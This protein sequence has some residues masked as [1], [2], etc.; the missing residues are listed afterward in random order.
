MADLIAAI[1]RARQV[2]VEAGGFTFTVR[3][4]TD[5][6]VVQLQ[7]D[8]LSAAELVQRFVIGW[9]GVQ[10]IH[11]VPGGTSVAVPFDAALWRE[12]IADQ[13][14]LWA[15][16]SSAIM[17]SYAAHRAALEDAAKNSPPGSNPPN[18]TD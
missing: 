5:L 1:R 14:D 18:S 17:Q 9:Q 13:P 7:N 8:G 11:L 10:E 15:P 12:W 4:P 2:N 3:R 6:E 16:I